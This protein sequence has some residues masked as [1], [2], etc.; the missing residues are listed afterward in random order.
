MQPEKIENC[1]K[2]I[3]AVQCVKQLVL[4]TCINRLTRGRLS[5]SLILDARKCTKKASLCASID[6]NQA[7][8]ALVNQQ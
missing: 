3:L 7:P 4:L 1:V 6:S 2:F 8:L 5:Q